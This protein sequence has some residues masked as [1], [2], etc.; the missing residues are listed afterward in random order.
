MNYSELQRRMDSFIPK[1]ISIKPV[2]IKLV[3]SVP[4]LQ[5]SALVI[6]VPDRI[7]AWSS[8]SLKFFLKFHVMVTNLLTIIFSI[9]VVLLP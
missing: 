6:K 7:S 5:R 3:F 8:H 4:L 1:S 9:K 2:E